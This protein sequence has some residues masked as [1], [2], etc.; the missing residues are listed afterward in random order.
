MTAYHGGKQRIGKQIAKAITQWLYEN[1]ERLGFV[2][3]GYCEPF[4]GMLGVYRHMLAYLPDD[5]S[6]RA[7]DINQSV[8]EMWNKAKRGWRPDTDR[9]LTKEKFEQLKFDSQPS[10]DKGFFGHVYTYRGVFFDGFFNHAISKVRSSADRIEQI[11]QILLEKQVKI[12]SGNYQQFS[13]LTGYIIYCDPPYAG[14]EQR[15]YDGIGYKNRLKFDQEEFWRWCEKMIA[16]NIIFLS[17]YN[18]PSTIRNGIVTEI[19]ADKAEK[20]FVWHANRYV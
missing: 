17:E 7:G 14:S 10:A 2:Y 15:F 4:C 8:I 9:P 11:G 13:D 18:R 20:L 16:T 19:W 6:F 12:T 1:V 3:H 5:I